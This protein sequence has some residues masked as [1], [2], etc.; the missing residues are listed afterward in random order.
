METINLS[1]IESFHF[2]LVASAIIFFII[3][4]Y[5]SYVIKNWQMFWQKFGVKQFGPDYSKMKHNHDFWHVIQ[6]IMIG[7]YILTMSIIYWYFYRWASV[8]LFICLLSVYWIWD[9]WL[10]LLI[11]EKLLY[12]SKTKLFD[13][14][15]GKFNWLIRILVLL[16]SY[17]LVIIMS[18]L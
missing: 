4:W 16:V 5:N 6:S 10:N 15:G 9:V 12:R 11:G 2:I 14:I 3:K 18:K 13:N 1:I 8:P 17:F 7:V